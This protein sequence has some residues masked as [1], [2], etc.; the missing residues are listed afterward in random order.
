[1]TRMAVPT[2]S[3][4]AVLPRIFLAAFISLAVVWL[5]RSALAIDFMLGDTVRVGIYVDP[6]V[7]I[8]ENYGGYSGLGVELWE[9]IAKR[10]RVNTE[11]VVFTTFND[12]LDACGSGKV[13]IV[14]HTVGVN[15]RRASYLWYSFPWHMA[16][17]RIMTLEQTSSSFWDEFQRFHH[18]RAYAIFGIIFVVMVTF[19]TLLRR[20]LEKE[21]PPD[22]K[23]GV[24]LCM[25]DV[26]KALRSGQLNQS[27][28]GWFGCL[29]SVVW[30]IFG[31]TASA[32]F[33]SS[34]AS[35]MTSSTLQRRELTGLAQLSGKR[36]GVSVGDANQQSLDDL[37]MTTVHY[38]GLEAS[39]KA[40][41]AGEVD[42]VVNTGSSLE[43]Y[44]RAHPELP[45]QVVGE[46]F[47]AMPC[48]FVTAREN[49]SFMD[50][51]SVELIW[52]FETGKIEDLRSRY[53]SGR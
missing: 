43:W 2:R 49:V 27:R 50:K 1:M 11:Y 25:R 39:I 26:L 19:M 20:K 51:V 44:D 4:S 22:W 17:A 48:G 16:A 8:E 52:L 34:I 5:P 24:T 15:S 41:L 36:I 29:L 6:P 23:T 21:F 38:H 9:I 35:A 46:S 18:F 45:V 14:V 30:M 42:A 3:R 40:L 33:T 13:D 47:F 7:T 32:Y 28:M 37:G 12:M 53:I 10:M 31:V